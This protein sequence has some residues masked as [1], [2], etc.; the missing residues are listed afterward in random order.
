MTQWPKLTAL[1]IGLLII[2]GIEL[3]SI[4]NFFVLPNGAIYD[5]FC[6]LPPKSTQGS[7]KV[8]IV[9]INPEQLY[10]DDE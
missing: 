8:I 9:P 2:C 7:K 10:S 1:N 4:V 5:T 3:L 6:K